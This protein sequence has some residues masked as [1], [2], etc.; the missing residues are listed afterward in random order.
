MLSPRSIAL[1]LCI[2]WCLMDAPSSEYYEPP[3]G[4]VS[5]IPHFGAHI[6]DS[7]IAWSHPHVLQTWQTFLSLNFALVF[8]VQDYFLGSLE[9]PILWKAI[10]QVLIIEH[11]LAHKTL[12]EFSSPQVLSRDSSE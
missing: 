2:S 6:G 1:N 7:R 4:S 11:V 9:S 3:I 10:R 12:V 5:L 8:G